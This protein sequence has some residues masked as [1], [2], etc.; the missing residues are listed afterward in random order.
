MKKILTVMM[1]LSS[2]LFANDT[3][4]ILNEIKQLRVDMDK[5]FENISNILYIL[6]ALIFASPFITIHLRDKKDAEDK[7]NFETLK[8]ILYTLRELAQDDEK[9]AKPMRAASLL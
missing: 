4:K 1:L 7:K 3:D 5:R 8:G 9:I 2:F 6:M